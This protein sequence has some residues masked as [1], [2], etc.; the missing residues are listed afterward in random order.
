MGG[1]NGTGTTEPDRYPRPLTNVE[2]E[3]LESVLPEDRPGYRRYRDLLSK[4]VVLGEGR[5]GRGN[6]ILGYHGDRADT[7]SPLPP[8][9]AFGG[10]EESGRE[11]SITIREFTG[12]Q[13]DVEILMRSEEE[14]PASLTV[15][16]RWTFSTWSPGLASPQSGTPVREVPITPKAA[17]A[18]S[19]QDHRVWI[20]DEESGMNHL[21]P[22]TGFYG[23]LMRIRSIRDPEVALKPGRFF[24]E[25]DRYSDSDLQ[26]AFVAYNKTRQR[27]DMGTLPPLDKQASLGER[28]SR[29]FGLRSKNG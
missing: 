20:F 14:F 16:R 29:L 2:L 15:N 4:M 6:L 25:L 13:I 23:E 7:T 24:A 26:E 27:I 3:I 11:L 18:I 21:L 5:R 9:I 28:L 8:V 19:S 17:L 1:K 22:I 10:I 12:N